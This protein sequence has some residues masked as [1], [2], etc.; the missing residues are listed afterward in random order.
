MTADTPDSNDFS[1]LTYTF[2]GTVPGFSASDPAISIDPFTGVIKVVDPSFFNYEALR[3]PNLSIGDLGEGHIFPEW[4]S[5][6]RA[7]TF[8]M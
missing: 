4:A 6:R 7:F 2:Q 8:P 3:T 1:T 5:N